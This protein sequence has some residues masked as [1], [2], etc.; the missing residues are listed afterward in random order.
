MSTVTRN[1]NSLVMFGGKNATD[2]YANDLYQVTQT[3]ETI[4]WKIL[5]QNNPPPG[6]LYGQ[7]VITNN[8]NNMYLLGGSTSASSTQMPALQSYQYSFESNTWTASPNNSLVITNTTLFPYNRK[9][10]TA[11]YDNQ[12]GIY[13]FGGAFNGSIIFNDFFYLDI[14]TQQYT[15]LPTTG[16]PQYGHTA[17]LLS[18]GKLVII[19]G[20]VE[21]PD[22]DRILQ[23][24]SSVFVFD[25]KSRTWENVNVTR[26]GFIPS[27][28]TSHSA[29]VTS[30]DRIIIFGGSNESIER[31]SMYL[32]AIGILDTKNWTWSTPDA[33]GIPPFRRSSA[34]AGLLNGNYLTV[35]FGASRN[36]F[37]NDINIY[38]ITHRKWLQSFA[39]E[40]NYGFRLTGGAIAGITVACI[41]FLVIIFILIRTFQRWI[42]WIV[43]G[44]YSSIWKPRYGEPTWAETTRI[45][46]QVIL[47][48]IFSAFLVFILLQ[49]INSPNI[50]QTIEKP[51][52]S[53]QVPDVRF[54]FDGFPPYNS[55][56]IR[57]PGVTC[58]TDI[59]YPCTEYVRPLNMSIFQPTFADSFGSVNCFLFRSPTDFF[60]TSTLGQ[61]NGSRLLFNFWGDQTIEHGSI[62]VSIYPKTMNPNTVMYN[63]LDGPATLMT[64][65]SDWI[66]NEIS[67]IQATNVFDIQPFSYSSISYNLVDHTHLQS[68]GWN[69]IGFSPVLNSTPEVVSNFR[70]EAPNSQYPIGHPDIGFIAI[71]PEAFVDTIKREVK[72]YTLVNALGFVGGTLG[73][74]IAVQTWLIG[75]RPRSPWGVVHRWSMGDMKRSLLINLRSKFRITD[76]GVPLVHPVSNRYSINEF[77]GMQYATEAQRIHRVEERIQTLE[78]MFKAYYVDD[79]IFR[80]L[81]DANEAGEV[82]PTRDVRVGGSHSVN[83]SG[84]FPPFSSLQASPRAQNMIDD[85]MLTRT[86]SVRKSHPDHFLQEFS[87]HDTGQ[88]GSSDIPLIHIQHPDAPPRQLN[89]SVQN[90]DL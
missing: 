47:F 62:H 28:R 29:I 4:N 68:V 6:T 33:S 3:P 20:V 52:T 53:V 31:Q 11:T 77:M 21:D 40:D 5:E 45:V 15:R 1:G 87:R 42:R 72:V 16:I 44:L 30:D 63:I 39:P 74:L 73:L 24:M 19:G 48:F 50:T 22:G 10:H 70:Q 7:A 2:L 88:S 14:T 64:S 26:Q 49:A 90:N 80:S 76:S 32:N 65:I 18:N 71:F 55:T 86:S 27:A 85:E 57:M 84:Q 66:N 67:D 13:I 12:N 54:C 59:G 69:Y 43:R 38:D 8:N 35:A 17:S 34:S 75:F 56:D 82:N 81:N 9:L 83:D 61:N 23:S 89:T 58:M 41:V 79:E 46:L 60:L 78:L 37:F 51:V 36:L 25:T